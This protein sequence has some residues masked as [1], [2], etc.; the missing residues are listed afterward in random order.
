METI[1]GELR[2]GLELDDWDLG[3]VLSGLP[4]VDEVGAGARCGR[5]WSRSIKK[6]SQDWAL[7]RS[8]ECCD[9][10]TLEGTD[11]P[12]RVATLAAKALRPDPDDLSGP[13]VAAVCVHPDLVGAAK[14]ALGSAPVAVAAVASSFPMGRAPLASKLADIEAAV[15]AGADEIDVVIDRAAF[16]SGR[17]R[18][19]LDE[20][21]AFKSVCGSAHLKVIL[22]TGELGSLDAVR[23]ASWLAMI[24]GA[25]FIKTST[26]KISIGATPETVLV[27]VQAARDFELA[28][29]RVVGVKAAGGI[30]SAKDAVRYLVLV[31][32]TAGAEFLVPSRWRLGVSSLL[33][34]L[35]AQRRHLRSGVY[36]AVE[37]YVPRG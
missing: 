12:A 7:R 19:A 15:L 33:D 1:W 25:D 8:I 9:L 26:G 10:T 37:R 29:G 24:S 27:L 35:V 23:Q 30:R 16:L 17:Y 34:D 32:E 21:R 13:S 28:T 11:T 4:T 18:Y 3:R 14:D 6:E 36:P 22:E 2:E 31:R 20:L 5:L